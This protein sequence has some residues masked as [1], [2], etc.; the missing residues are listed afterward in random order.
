MMKIAGFSIILSSLFFQTIA[1]AEDIKELTAD[2]ETIALWHMGAVKNNAGFYQI[3]D[4]VGHFKLQQTRNDLSLQVVDSVG[5]SQSL[6]GFSNH[7]GSLD[8]VD[9]INAGLPDSKSQTFE[10]W[11]KWEN[12][13]SLPK[14]RESTK[15]TIMARLVGLTSSTWLYF[16]DNQIKLSV[17]SGDGRRDEKVYTADVNPRSGVWYHVAFTIEMNDFDTQGDKNDTRVNLYFNDVNNTD[18]TPEPLTNIAT[19]TKGV[20]YEDFEYRANGWLFR[21]GKRYRFSNA[22]FRGLIN[23]VRLSNVAKTTF[24]VFGVSNRQELTP[25]KPV[26]VKHFKAVEQEIIKVSDSTEKN[27]KVNA[28]A[29]II[30]ALS[31]TINNVKAFDLDANTIALWHMDSIKNKT[32]SYQIN[33]VTGRFHLQQTRKNLALQL[34]NSAGGAGRSVT[35]F[36]NAT[37]SLDLVDA[38]HANLPDSTAQTFE[39]WIKWDNERLLPQNRAS[40]KQTIMARIVSSTSS[41][42][43][44][45]VNG[46]IK[47]SIRSGDG[48]QQVKTYTAEVKPQ[49]GI[50][51]HVAFTIE[52]N[53]F[54]RQG[55]KKDTQV[56]LYFNDENNTD[57]TPEPLLDIATSSKGV[58][59]E[60]FKYRANGW[61]FRLGKRHRISNAPFRGLIDEVRL[62][63]VVK[64]T[65]DV[66]GR[67]STTNQISKSSGKGPSSVE[68][69]IV[70]KIRVAEGITRKL[71]NI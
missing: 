49:A 56:K 70:D 17:R 53:D 6:S 46:Q 16:V 3:N 50:W 23:D 12:D 5:A 26:S 14:H 42:W 8:L 61:L 39:A 47:L 55:D 67:A 11:I 19:K 40:K 7:T 13:N 34:V 43:L 69:E 51:Y 22:Q 52:V 71:Q 59:Y 4:E 64:T 31:P 10:A 9:A 24:N 60:D 29:P 41:S 27:D 58:M 68:A 66:F 63:N 57:S 28:L 62:S 45:F 18:S 30:P 48:Q 38:I 44:Y 20:V 65:F 37:G 33:D 32:G 21:L 25:T 1:R 36:N 35:G 54:D 15:Q 2:D